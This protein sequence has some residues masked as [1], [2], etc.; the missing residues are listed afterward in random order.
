MQVLVGSAI[1]LSQG[2]Y[3]IKY[4]VKELAKRIRE[5]RECDVQNLKLLGRYLKGTKEYGH[6]TKLDED[7]TDRRRGN[8]TTRIL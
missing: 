4:S 2:K 5:P 7:V 3:D 8:S 1:Y 6:V